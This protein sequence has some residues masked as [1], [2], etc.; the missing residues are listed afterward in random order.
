M[1]EGVEHM[2]IFYYIL[3]AE[4]YSKPEA[5]NKMAK[6]IGRKLPDHLICC[7]S[8]DA[9]D[10]IAEKILTRADKTIKE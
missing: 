4:A 9:A 10:L 1:V 8:E 7:F 5:M 3:Q 2:G 6:I